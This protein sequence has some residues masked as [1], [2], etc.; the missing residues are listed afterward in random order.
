MFERIINCVREKKID[1][2]HTRR[3]KKTTKQ[4]DIASRIEEM[5]NELWIVTNIKLLTILMTTQTTEPNWNGGA[6]I[7]KNRLDWSLFIHCVGWFNWMYIRSECR[8]T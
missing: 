2:T 5:K 4:I 7:G 1:E 8:H 6:A 3:G